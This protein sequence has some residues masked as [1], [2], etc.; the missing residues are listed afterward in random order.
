MPVS[1]HFFHILKALR[2]NP[3]RNWV[4]ATVVSKERSSYRLPGAMMLVDSDGDSLGLVSGGCLEADIRLNARKVQSMGQ[5]RCVL[6]DSL[7]EGNIAAELG[8]GCNG[9]VEVLVQELE[10]THREVLIA[11][12]ERME[13]GNSSYLLHCYQSDQPEDLKSL[14]LL[15]ESGTPLSDLSSIELPE[16]P[17]LSPN[18]P[19]QLLS[20]QHQ[21]WSL[22][23]YRP[24]VNL[25]VFGGGVDAQPMVHL[26]ASL[27]W[28]VTL[29]DHRPAYAR[30]MDFPD[31]EIFVRERPEQFGGELNA[32][33]A[34]LMTH[35]LN[36]DAAWLSRLS[37]V[38]SLRYIGILGPRDRKEEALAMAGIGQDSPLLDL[39]YGPMGIDIGGDIPESVALSTLAQIHQV[40]FQNDRRR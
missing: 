29:V 3:S 30:E 37:T 21:K 1:S 22:S 6:Y 28:R 24:P 2:D 15:D 16:L 9:R 17:P 33:A 35:N 31:V 14:I 39:L 38:S 19:H 12:L 34:I 36:L 32:D 18:R 5:A 4:S 20:R 11:L 13:S 26:A 40:F 23:F 8:L 25:W 7:D 27:G 10:S